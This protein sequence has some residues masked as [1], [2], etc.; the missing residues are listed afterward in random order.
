MN[1]IE[2][3]FKYIA[4]LLYIEDCRTSTTDLQYNGRI[5]TTRQGYANIGKT[6][7]YTVQKNKFIAELLQV[8]QIM[9]EVHGVIPQIGGK[10]VTYRCVEVSKF[11]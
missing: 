8:V 5:N 7:Q 6:A 1:N 4:A 10:G 3:N 9:L 11:L 2:I